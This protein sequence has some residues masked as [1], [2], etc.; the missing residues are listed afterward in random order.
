MREIELR[1]FLVA[2]LEASH[3]PKTAGLHIKSGESH[4]GPW[5]GLDAL[6]HCLPRILDVSQ[7]GKREETKLK[8]GWYM[9]LGELYPKLA[10]QFAP[11]EI[12]THTTDALWFWFW[13]CDLKICHFPSG[14]ICS[15][16]A[17]RSETFGRQKWQVKSVTSHDLT[18]YGK[19]S[20]LASRLYQA[21]P[22]WWIIYS[23]LPTESAFFFLRKFQPPKS[24]M[25]P[26]SWKRRFPL[27]TIIFGVPC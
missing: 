16:T 25:E 18:L 24:N 20:S 10:E 12:H 2:P 6:W 14:L 3:Y 4:R 8:Q 11:A 15:S 19:F 1:T 23:N 22:G 17:V 13:M 27:Q 5:M 21:N 26:E 7:S 9:N